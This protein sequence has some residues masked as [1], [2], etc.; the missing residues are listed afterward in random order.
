MK[1]KE[2]WLR[3]AA[4]A[5]GTICIFAIEPNIMDKTPH[6]IDMLVIL[7]GLA[8]LGAALFGDVDL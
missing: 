7:G 6:M 2:T 8:L 4:A 1:D 5:L 3:R